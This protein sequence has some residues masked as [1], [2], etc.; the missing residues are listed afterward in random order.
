VFDLV[1]AGVKITGIGVHAMNSDEERF[2]KFFCEYSQVDKIEGSLK[3]YDEPLFHNAYNAALIEMLVDDDSLEFDPGLVVQE[4]PNRTESLWQTAW[5]ETY[6]SSDGETV[7]AGY[8]RPTKPV[9]NRLRVAL[10]IHC[11][12]EYPVVS[13][14]GKP[15]QLP[16][17]TAMPERLWQ[18]APYELP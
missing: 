17:I 9:T 10:F 4:N 18:L 16:S 3:E 15:L 5:N 6:L 2:R 8:P 7:I 14:A 1:G 11:F 13:Y 12:S